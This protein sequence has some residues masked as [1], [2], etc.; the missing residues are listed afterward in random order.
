M[1]VFKKVVSFNTLDIS[2]SALELF[3]SISFN[4]L[5]HEAHPQQ[6]N[7]DEKIISESEENDDKSFLPHIDEIL[8]SSA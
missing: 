1:K 4:L 3:R 5:D 8:V 7:L 6:K 2:V